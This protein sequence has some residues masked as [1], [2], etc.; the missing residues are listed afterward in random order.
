MQAPLRSRDNFLVT[1]RVEK[2]T[3]A[4]VVFEQE[5]WAL[6]GTAREESVRCVHAMATICS[7]DQEHRPTR[8][9]AGLAGSFK[10]IKAALDEA[11]AATEALN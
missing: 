7:L 11:L 3:P 2:I 10:A 1:A 9:P 4:R 8:V 6:A 5:I